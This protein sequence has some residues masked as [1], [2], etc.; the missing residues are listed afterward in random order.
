MK[1]LTSAAIVAITAAVIG[2][3]PLLT[4]ASAQQ[5]QQQANPHGPQLQMPFGQGGHNRFM[6]R[7][8]FGDMRQGAARMGGLLELVCSERGAEQL[9]VGLVRL[10]YRLNLTAGQQPLFDD[11]KASALA[12]QT[13]FADTCAAAR[14]TASADAQQ[15]PVDPVARMQTRIAI[16]KAHTAALETVLPKLEALYNALTDAQKAALQ[17]QRGQGMRPHMGQ[18][19]TEQDQPGD[20]ETDEPADSIQG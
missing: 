9:E 19:P 4:I 16:E 13:Q 8:E 14:P 2:A 3:G 18:L 17:P 20:V 15:Q 1:P 7:G 5:A 10:A 6:Q 12:A 11:L